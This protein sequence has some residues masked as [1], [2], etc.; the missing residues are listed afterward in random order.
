MSKP[1][2]MSASVIHVTVLM[3]CRC[4]GLVSKPGVMSASVIHVTVLMCCRYGGLVSKP[5]VMSASVI[6]V[7]V[8]GICMILVYCTLSGLAGVYS[9]YILK[10][11]YNV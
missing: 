3:C 9:E 11:K 8:L 7:T 4:G 1:G 2:V 10:D 6:H 5:G